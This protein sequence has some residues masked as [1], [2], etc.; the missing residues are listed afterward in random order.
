MGCNYCKKLKDSESIDLPGKD[1]RVFMNQFDNFLT[2]TESEKLKNEEFDLVIPKNYLDITNDNAFNLPDEFKENEKLYDVEPI[3]FKNGNIYKGKW[4]SEKRM[5]GKGKYYLKDDGIYIE[6][7]W[8]NGDLKYGRIFL[9]D[10]SIYKGYINNSKYN[11]KGKLILEDAEYDGE[12]E[13]GDFK[14]G[15]LVWKNGY[16]YDGDFNGFCLNG[17]GKLK[18]PDG[19]SYEG[20]FVNNLFHGE[21]TYKYFKS[22]NI[23]EGEFQYGMKKG[24]GKYTVNGQYIYE[25]NWDNDMPFGYGKLSNWDDTCNLKCTFRDGKIAE[26]PIYIKGSKEIINPETFEIKPEEM[27]I[28]ITKLSHINNQINNQEDGTIIFKPGSIRSFFSDE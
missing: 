21:G 20:D 3:K 12:F 18:N 15:K 2:E 7:F 16:E 10:G 5:E 6:G 23:Y 11:G 27:N 22:K 28:N 24:K 26:E 25:G 1:S 4:N 9:P 13:N 14:K 17:K 8:D 19:D